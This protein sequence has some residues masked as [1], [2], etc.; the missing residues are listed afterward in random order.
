VLAEKQEWQEEYRQLPPDENVPQGCWAKEEGRAIGLNV[1]I[2]HLFTVHLAD[3]THTNLPYS[4]ADT[5]SSMKRPFPFFSVI[6]V[7]PH[8]RQDNPTGNIRH[9]SSLFSYEILRWKRKW[10]SITRAQLGATVL[11]SETS[12][13]VD[14]GVESW[15]MYII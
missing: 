5:S 14:M 3:A 13:R 11:W 8:E 1:A 12:H 6:F 7:F 2:D 9:L 10:R 4:R 15:K